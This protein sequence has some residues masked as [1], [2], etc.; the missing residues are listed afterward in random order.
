MSVTATKNSGSEWVSG[1]RLVRILGLR[2]TR[3][4]TDLVDAGMP[5]RGRGREREY[6]LET[7]AQFYIQYK[8]KEARRTREPA[9]FAKARARKLEAEASKAEIELAQL[10]G[11]LLPVAEFRKELTAVVD[12]L[13]SVLVSVPSKYLSS[14]RTAR[15]DVDT[16]AVLE[17]LRDE[18]LV[19]LQEAGDDAED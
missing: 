8:E 12:R 5:H 11:R 1:K 2:S 7:A 14:V 15:T 16:I 17:T 10:E 19:A 6:P 9:D 13:H 3:R 18:T 4:L